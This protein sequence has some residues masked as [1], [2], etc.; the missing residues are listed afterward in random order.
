VDQREHPLCD[1]RRGC[2]W[3]RSSHLAGVVSP[4]T[5][6]APGGVPG[7]D[8]WQ[9]RGQRF[10]YSWGPQATHGCLCYALSRIG[11]DGCSRVLAAVCAPAEVSLR[12]SV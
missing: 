2:L 9:S 5:S 10:C 4:G 1:M 12:G 8:Q 11:V 7:V 6:D 3:W